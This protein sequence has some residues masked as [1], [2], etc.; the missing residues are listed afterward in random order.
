MRGS[1]DAGQPGPQQLNSMLALVAT[2]DK[3]S[4]SNNLATQHTSPAAS[5]I[6]TSPKS[7]PQSTLQTEL[8]LEQQRQVQSDKQQGGVVGTATGAVTVSGSATKS[9]QKQQGTNKPSINVT[10]N[11]LDISLCGAQPPC[12]AST[13]TCGVGTRGRGRTPGNEFHFL[14]RQLFRLCFNPPQTCSHMA[15]CSIMSNNCWKIEFFLYVS[16]WKCYLRQFP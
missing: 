2:K 9:S 3:L 11:P 15:H 10:T 8:G 12:G 16:P 6:A 14:L 5:I 1:V 13:Q 4:K 7:G